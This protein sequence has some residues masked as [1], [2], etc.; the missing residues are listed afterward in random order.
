MSIKKVKYGWDDRQ[1][2][3][4]LQSDAFWKKIKQYGS[5]HPWFYLENDPAFYSNILARTFR[6]VHILSPDES[7]EYFDEDPDEN[8]QYVPNQIFR[9]KRKLYR[10]R[11]KKCRIKSKKD[12]RFKRQYVLPGCSGFL[13]S[14]NL[15]LTAGH[16]LYSINENTDSLE[17]KYS[18]EQ[19]KKMR[20]IIGFGTRHDDGYQGLPKFN[21]SRVFKVCEEVEHD[22]MLK[23][24]WAILRLSDDVPGVDDFEL[25]VPDLEV[26]KSQIYMLGHPLGLPMKLTH[27][28]NIVAKGAGNYY[29][30]LDAFIGNSGSAIFRA[31]THQLVGLLA[32]GA[33]DFQFRRRI[34]PTN[35]KLDFRT[36]NPNEYSEWRLRTEI[37]QPI[38]QKII[39]AVKAAK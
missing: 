7:E 37:I 1:N 26:N 9:Q 32:G 14:K 23:K 16:C 31:D 29:T 38:N 34:W 36:F 6:T 21:A 11:G 17:R 20:V 13:I 19:I 33:A 10:Y 5:K 15:L 18:A 4:S 28:G 22:V 35:Q 25:Q 27:T 39:K 3:L 12:K 30:N 2:I 24:D 8:G